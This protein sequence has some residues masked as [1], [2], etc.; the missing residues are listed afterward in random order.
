MS[1]Y[2]GI[3]VG[4]DGSQLFLKT[5]DCGVTDTR[6][7]NHTHSNPQGLISFINNR[8]IIMRPIGRTGF[9]DINFR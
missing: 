2:K 7:F 9:W 4:H 3:I 1:E 5:A 8:E 6:V